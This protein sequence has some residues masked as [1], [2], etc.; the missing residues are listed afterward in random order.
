MKMM[1]ICMSPGG[2]AVDVEA[3]PLPM[4][5]PLSDQSSERPWSQR[6]SR[7]ASQP[8]S[9]Y[10]VSERSWSQPPSRPPSQHRR[11]G[12]RPHLPHHASHASLQHHRSRPSIARH[13]SQPSLNTSSA[14]VPFPEL[15][16]MDPD[17]PD[18]YPPHPTHRAANSISYPPRREAVSQ[19]HEHAF[20]VNPTRCNSHSGGVT[21][22]ERHQKTPP[23]SVSGLSA[24]RGLRTR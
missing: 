23:F 20:C 8:G 15:P 11:D 19:R 22:V 14:R 1:S 9:P 6:M 24:H 3:V 2:H 5:S 17:M 7:P 18:T 13:G 16:E 12:S 21:E 10:H 4:M